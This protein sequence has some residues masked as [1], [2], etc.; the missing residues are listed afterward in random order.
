M[1]LSLLKG[2]GNVIMHVK[3]VVSLLSILM[4]RRRKYYNDLNKSFQKLSNI[5]IQ[6]MCLLLE[7][8]LFYCV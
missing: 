7:V 8:R 3:E 1:I 2:I 4:E 6:I 5:E